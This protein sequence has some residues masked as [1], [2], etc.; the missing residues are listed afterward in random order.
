MRNAKQF[1]KHANGQSAKS[2]KQTGRCG[3]L[4]HSISGLHT[5]GNFYSQ[6]S[7]IEIPYDAISRGGAQMRWIRQFAYTPIKFLDC[8]TGGI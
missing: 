4:I 6:K 3:R 5:I 2:G 8:G 1:V 7:S